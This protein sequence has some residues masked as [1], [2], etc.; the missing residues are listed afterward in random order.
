MAAKAASKKKKKT[1]ATTT[2]KTGEEPGGGGGPLRL[3]REGIESEVGEEK[4]TRGWVEEGFD[5]T[6]GRK[7]E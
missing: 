3:D 2:K 6:L 1:P 7:R 4:V 5:L